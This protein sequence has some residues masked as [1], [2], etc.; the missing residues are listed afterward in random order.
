[1]IGVQFTQATGERLIENLITAATV[2]FEAKG[3]QV[4]GSA[5][6]NSVAANAAGGSSFNDNFW[7]TVEGGLGVPGLRG[8]ESHDSSDPSPATQID[9]APRTLSLKQGSQESLDLSGRLP[10]SSW[11]QSSG[12]MGARALGSGPASGASEA[13]S[14]HLPGE[15]LPIDRSDEAESQSSSLTGVEEESSTVGATAAEGNLGLSSVDGRTKSSTVA[16]LQSGRRADIREGDPGGDLQANKADL[17]RAS[18]SPEKSPKHTSHDPGLDPPRSLMSATNQ[19]AQMADVHFPA[20]QATPAPGVD[21]ANSSAQIFVKANDSTIPTARDTGSIR[22]N[23]AQGSVSVDVVENGLNTAAVESG[24]VQSVSSPSSPGTS[25]SSTVSGDTPSSDSETLFAGVDRGI[26]ASNREP[27]E[28]LLR[29]GPEKIDP[30]ISGRQDSTEPSSNSLSRPVDSSAKDVRSTTRSIGPSSEAVFGMAKSALHSAVN[31]NMKLPTKASSS[32]IAREQGSVRV[33]I[34][35]PS[36]IFS[37]AQTASSTVVADRTIPSTAGL[38]EVATPQAQIGLHQSAKESS[39]RE[40]IDSAAQGSLGEG[41]GNPSPMSPLVAGSFP[42]T[43]PLERKDMSLSVPPTANPI[44]NA[45]GSSSPLVPAT[46]PAMMN[47][48]RVGAAAK[49]TEHASLIAAPPES[50]IGSFDRAEATVSVASPKL[51]EVGMAS[52][53]NGWLKVRAESDSGGAVSASLIA[54][55]ANAAEALHKDL[56]ALTAYLKDQA[57][58]V[59]S[60]VVHRT[61]PGGSTQDAVTT[62]RQD[63]F[64]RSEGNG[65]QQGEPDRGVKSEPDPVQTESDYLPTEYLPSSSI[66]KPVPR[67]SGWF[68]AIA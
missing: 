48:G 41:A 4:V 16:K 40:L 55:T 54:N 46:H 38:L 11:R 58:T 47:E 7:H 60:L 61:E 19:E 65:G 34:V 37:P 42:S 59:N 9:A 3:S 25:A 20:L 13:P 23:G 35:T 10:A 29:A 66:D 67:A 57:L 12:T 44:A 2:P 53:S 1:M 14:I 50:R 56:P 51:L 17:P 36:E 62:S 6:R 18:K 68:N 27:V 30:Q 21:Q 64:G 33:E 43:G 8:E 22:V 32:P 15:P 39:K 24:N 52:G 45:E 28:M 49:A 26:T 63:N 31:A 5:L